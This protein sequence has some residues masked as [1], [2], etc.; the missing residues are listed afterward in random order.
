MLT[1]NQILDIYL[2]DAPQSRRAGNYLIQDWFR[3]TENL[4]V[5]D[6]ETVCNEMI[7]M[8][9]TA[10]N[11]IRWFES[12]LLFDM[13]DFIKEAR[14]SSKSEPITISHYLPFGSL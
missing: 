6:V 2:D 13:Q 1:L 10:N 3:R 12:D 14:V 11:A 8:P 5:E 7:D 9:H 4:A